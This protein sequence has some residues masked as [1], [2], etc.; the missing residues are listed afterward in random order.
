MIKPGQKKKTL[1]A[2]I[3]E[4][5]LKENKFVYKTIKKSYYVIDCRDYTD[6]Y[7]GFHDSSWAIDEC[8][9]LFTEEDLN[10]IKDYDID[11]MYYI[12]YSE[13]PYSTVEMQAKV[14]E[15]L[16]AKKQRYINRVDEIIN[17]VLK[18]TAERFINEKDKD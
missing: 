6:G 16:E 12:L 7:Y 13:R 18:A 2:N 15:V 17:Q 1:Y 11:Y 3:L 5:V 4:Y 9:W 8:Q 14:K 10:K